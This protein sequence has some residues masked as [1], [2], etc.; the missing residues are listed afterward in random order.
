MLY[1]SDALS[2][3]Q[4]EHGI[5]EIRFDSAGSVNK[6]DQCTLVSFDQALQC[7][8][9]MSELSGVI[10]SHNKADFMVGAD[11]T[12][13]L[14][15]FAL[16][17][18][19][20]SEWLIKAND[21]FNRLEDLN[22]PTITAMRGFALGGGCECA[23]ASDYRI[24]TSSL[25]I[26]LPEV[27]LGIMP[28]FGGSVRLPRLIG[29]DNALLWITTGKQFHAQAALA[30]GVLDAVVDHEHLQHAALD[31]LRAAIAGKLDWQ[32]R[33][34]QK[35]SPLTLSA[36]EAGMCFAT[37]NAM[38]AAKAGHH[39]P[40]PITAVKAIEKAAGLARDEALMVENKHFV[41]LAKTNVARSLVGIFLNDQNLKQ[42]AKKIAKQGKDVQHLAVL[43]AGIMGG[44][45]AYQGASN[46][47]TTVM[48][49]INPGALKLGMREANKLL[50]KQLERG[51]IDG[52][53]LGETL[54]NIIPSLHYGSLSNADVVIEAV[55]E[56]PK[57]KAQVLAET[58]QHVSQDCVLASNTSTIPISLLSR[59]LTNPERF[60]GMH[61]FNPVHRMPLVEVI[62]GDQTS[63]ETI[64]TVVALASKMGKSA[65][66]V[67][68]CPGFFVN[69][70]LFPYFFGFTYLIA[71]G[72]DFAQIDKVME[73]Q[74]GWPMGPA[75][76]LDVVGIDTA[77]HAGEVMAQGYPT[78]MAKQQTDC[79]DIFY[80][81]QR[82]G[83]KNGE[84][85]Y[86][87]GR[88]KNGLF[89]KEIASSAYDLLAQ[90]YPV[91]AVIEDE[92]IIDYLMIPMVNEVLHCLDEGI[93][94][95]P[96]QA[97]I[98]LVYGLGFPPFRGGAI[99]WLQHLGLVEF[100]AKADALSHLG[101]LYQVPESLRQKAI[102]GEIYY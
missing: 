77:H 73:G 92:E 101:S 42:Q 82:F 14:P 81:A 7:L 57:V 80:Q 4:H 36:V 52:Q 97:D 24:A 35:K 90:H 45:I 15:K 26:G 34:Q 67:N 84:G 93:I 1:Q 78:R 48:K 20:L 40:A 51:R 70:V 9:G 91:D 49:D 38:V 23:L 25:V 68:D 75:Y 11:I 100:I 16:P 95:C 37:A 47:L 56:H 76:L 62:R 96:A 21:I 6:F 69:R 32:A 55:V 94:D 10:V 98:A 18:N 83:Q 61:F 29:A 99:A 31:M 3:I 30:V 28:G 63:E 71:K 85:F 33:R 59:S 86:H 60:C 88:D 79:I 8:Q 27:K 74:F 50:N 65:V 5:A 12:E 102:A 54:I 58:E 66:V 2:V 43:G 41:K 46:Q 44:G 64:N 39:Y 72:V 87:Y 17:D 19:E 13:F 53:T 89:V 22:V